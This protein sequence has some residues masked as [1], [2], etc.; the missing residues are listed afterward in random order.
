MSS[1]HRVIL[2]IEKIKMGADFR[3]FP[4]IVNQPARDAKEHGGEENHN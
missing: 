3:S 2:S 1:G 4:P